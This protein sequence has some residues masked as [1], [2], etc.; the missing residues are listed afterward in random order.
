MKNIVLILVM[1]IGV[2]YLNFAQSFS[3]ILPQ[4]DLVQLENEVNFFWN[5]SHS[6]ISYE[7]EID[8]V[9]ELFQDAQNYFIVDLDTTIISMPNRYYWRIREVFN[10][11]VGNWT[12][13]N[14]YDVINLE[15]LGT[16]VLWLNPDLNHVSINNYNL[17]REFE[18]SANNSYVISQLDSAYRPMYIENI[19]N[20]KPGLYFDGGDLMGSSMEVSFSSCFAV[21]K[22]LNNTNY[23]HSGL[24]GPTANPRFWLSV[25]T[26]ESINQPWYWGSSSWLVNGLQTQI[27]PNQKFN[28]VSSQ[29][30][31]KNLPNFHIAPFHSGMSRFKGYFLEQI[32][33]IGL[34]I[35]QRELV[36]DYLR[37]KYSPPINLGKDIE[38]EYG[39]CD[40]KLSVPT[41]IDSCIWSTGETSDSISINQTGQYW[42]EC[43]DVFGFISR[44]TI[45]VTINS[46][47]QPE[48]IIYCPGST[49]TWD[50]INMENDY[51]FF[52]SDGNTNQTNDIGLP[53]N[54]FVTITDT[55][56]CQ[57][58]SPTFLFSED[59]YPSQITLGNDT[60]LCSGN[61]ITF[62][63]GYG[64][65]ESFDWS[66]TD[67]TQSI[68]IENSGLY[69]I[70]A[71]NSNGCVGQD[72][73]EVTV[74]G[75]APSLSFSIE[76][77]VCQGSELSYSESSTVPPGNTIDQVVW[78]FGELDSIYSS[79]GTQSYADSGIYIGF[80]E[81]STLE[82][83]SSRE[84]FVIEVFPKPIISFE[85]TNYCPYEEIGFTPSNNYNVPLNSFNWNFDQDGNTSTEH[86]P[87]YSYGST[88]NYDV[89]LVAIDSN[90][91]IDT[92]I[93]SVYVQPSPLADIT[94]VNPCELNALEFSDNSSI[95]DTF[96]IVTYA[97]NYD[98]NTSAINPTE[99]KSFEEYGAYTVQ[100]VLT[101][102]NGCVDST[103]Q[104]I[105]VHPNPILNYGVGPAC[106][107]TWTVFEDLSTIPQGAL[108]ETNWLFNLQFEDNATIANF[109]FPTTG[110]QLITLSSTSDEGCNVDSTFTIDVS[111][112]LNANFNAD[113]EILVSDVPINFVNTS[114]GAD[115]SYW[116]FGNA[117]GLNYNNA[118]ENSITYSSLLNGTNVD[119]LLMTANDFGCR[120][121][122]SKTLLVNEAFYDINLETLFAQDIN[123]FLTVGVQIENLGTIPLENL[124]LTLKTPENGPIQENWSG[125]ILQSESEIYIFN[126][127]P[128]AFI[129]DQDATE[130]F[131]CVE[132]QNAN[133]SAYLDLNQD[134][135]TKC[136]NIEGEGLVLLSMF[137]NP[138]D[139]DITI[140]TLLT[141]SASLEIDFFDQTGRIAYK[142]VTP[143]LLKG[144]H[145][146]NIPFS[147]FDKGV[148]SVRIN[149][150]V[151]SLLH[152]II[153]Y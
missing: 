17:V 30:I 82:G 51:T 97:W 124:N 79:S 66:T 50:P 18:S 37:F 85:T 21:M 132:A 135:N 92:V 19:L 122:I 36:H 91:C 142:E 5:E 117:D 77:E 3:T 133:I 29:G 120:D 118:I 39:F 139:Q 28:I 71:I 89:G 55:N 72:T 128:S 60:S 64:E 14:H 33:Y 114:I 134:N 11:S 42:V 25:K 41:Y 93:Q 149:D 147:K 119:I 152:K 7:L 101:A 35:D 34:G 57:Y 131:V 123:G 67:T 130:R 136:K 111:E 103:E 129:S 45:N 105:I 9:S 2:S 32:A 98:D 49:V 141:T 151:N 4:R 78:N 61:Y 143:E 56:G 46:S 110:I 23:A 74:I 26:N 68:I 95:T 112:E 81:V 146:F 53:E 140:S 73:I 88:G 69:A 48:N 144:I 15:N 83:C 100:L 12:S 137:P 75:T 80:L 54:Y 6:A 16:L 38:Q 76:N 10:D 126:A 22:A 1:V 87:S 96:S 52:W 24:V 121:T 102:N 70:E 65:T 40:V 31:I 107:N 59:I 145:N 62:L 113:P 104:N 125:S 43:T 27:V 63:N 13:T 116:D 20:N 58:T 148:Y 127:Q 8:T 153:R 115:S 150:G 86:F 138:S 84:N 44:D 108:T 94:I 99:E 47:L 109:N 106:M 90:S